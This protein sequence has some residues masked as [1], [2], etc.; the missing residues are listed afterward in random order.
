VSGAAKPSIQLTPATGRDLAD[1]DEGELDDD[2][3]EEVGL[4][5]E[6]QLAAATIAPTATSVST[7]LR[8]EPTWSRF[9]TPPLDREQPSSSRT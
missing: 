4:D 7:T 5:D 2:E 8:T 3:V 9:T 6:L 1:V